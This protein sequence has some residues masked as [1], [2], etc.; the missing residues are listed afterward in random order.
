M[1]EAFPIQEVV[2]RT[3]LSVHA[4]WYYERAGL[5]KPVDRATSGHRR[6]TADDLNWIAFLLRLRA[7][8]M[9]IRHMQTY[10]DL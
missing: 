2:A 9:S 4:L 6:Y 3:G 5:L 10:A 7:T 1:E 8:G